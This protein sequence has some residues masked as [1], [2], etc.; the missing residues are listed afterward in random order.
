MLVSDVGRANVAQIKEALENATAR[1]D[2]AAIAFH[3]QALA[4]AEALLNSPMM[5]FI[6]MLGAPVGR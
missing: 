4:D 1:G 6:D 3:T 2:A 5:K